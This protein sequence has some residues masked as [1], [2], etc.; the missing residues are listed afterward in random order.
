M[1]HKFRYCN[2]TVLYKLFK[3]YCMS[4]YVSLLWDYE[5]SS[6][7][8]FYT[9]WRKC[10]RLLFKIPYNTHCDLLPT[11]CDD[12]SVE[13]QMYKR[14]MKFVKTSICSPS[15]AVRICMQHAIMG[16]GSNMS[17]SINNMCNV[18]GLDKHTILYTSPSHKIFKK[19]VNIN[20]QIIRECIR[21]R[22][23]E[24]NTNLDNLEIAFIIN[25]LCTE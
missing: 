10:I 16:S 8:I 20:G 18:I 1:L 12:L 9:A 24:L 5:H 19:V 15:K 23:N 22:E 17:N 4:L 25:F 3:S 7:N 2:S 11:I 6:V 21:I 14:I 13:Q